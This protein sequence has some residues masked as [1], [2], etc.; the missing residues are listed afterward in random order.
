MTAGLLAP[1]VPRLLRRLE[2]PKPG[3]WQAAG[4]LVFADISG[5]TRM[6]EKLAHQGK[7]GAEEM[8]TTIS[9]VFTALLQATTDGGDVLKFGGDALLLLYQ[10]PDHAHRACHAALT[11]QRELRRVGGIDTSRGRV[12]LRM[13][14]G[15]HSGRFHFLLCGGDHL[16]LHVLGP[17]ATTTTVLES[18]AGPGQVVASAATAGQLDGARIQPLSDG[19]M[20]IRAVPP[21]PPLPL[22][23]IGGGPAVTRFVPPPLRDHLASAETDS[24]HR[25]ATVAFV[26]F[27]QVDSLLRDGHG[28]GAFDRV[29]TLTTDVMAALEEYGVLLTATDIGGDGGKFMLTAGAPRTTGDEEARMLRVAR[30]IID[31][32]CGLPIRVGVNAGNVFVGAVGAPHR[33]T[34]STMGDATNLAARVMGRAEPGTVL[35]TQTVNAAAAGRFRVTPRPEFRVKGKSQPVL[36]GVVGPAVAPSAGT[37][38]D[39]PLVGRDTE[40]TE[41]LDALDEARFGRGRVV[42]LIGGEGVGKSRLVAELHDRADGLNWLA[43][44]CEPY[45]QA[46]PFV[47]ARRLIRL[48]LDLSPD[49][50]PEAAADALG[51]AMA[52][53]APQLLPWLPLIADVV[54]TSAEPTDATAELAPEFRSE[55]TV[56]AAAALLAA[57][58]GGGVTVVVLE[59]ATAM[60][61]ASAEVITELLRMVPELPWLAVVTRQDRPEGL[62]A[63]RGYAARQLDLAPLPRTAISRLAARLAEHYPVPTHVVEELVDRAA[64][65]PMVLEALIAAQSTA[66]A[67][68]QVPHT[69]EGI[70]AARIDALDDQTRRI[71]RYL[72]V[73]GDRA[74]APLVTVM[75]GAMVLGEERGLQQADWDGDPIDDAW[76]DRLEG[77]VVR[78][79]DAVVFRT[80]LIRQVAYEGLSFRRRRELHGLAA[81]ALTGLGGDQA[82][83]ALHLARAGRWAAAWDTAISAGDAAVRRG[84]HAAAGELYDLALSAAPHLPDLPDRES[85]KVALDAGAAWTR[86]GVNERALQAFSQAAACA[87]DQASCIEVL[88]ARAAVHEQAGRYTQALQSYGRA[89]SAVEELPPGIQQRRLTARTHTGYASA[90]LGQGR[91]SDAVEVGL[92]AVA[93]LDDGDDPSLLAHA[94][95]LLDRGYAMLGDADTAARYRDLALPLFAAQGDLVAQGTVL[96]DLGADANRQ[97]Q[98][99]V[100]LWLHERSREARARAGD[101]VGSAA[102]VNAIGEVLLQLGRHEE[103]AERFSDALRAWRGA[104]SLPGVALALHNLGTVALQTGA[105][106]S[107]AKRLEE[108]RQLA[109]EVGAEGLLCRTRLGLAEAL[110]ELGRVVEAWDAATTVLASGETLETDQQ[111]RAHAVRARALALTGGN[112]RAA[113]EQAA[114]DRLRELASR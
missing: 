4:T 66:G 64:G 17:D 19:S 97:G 47:T 48:A 94:Y 85:F 80:A 33:R 91:A 79:D 81:T 95:H 34:Y 102:A 3:A 52:D 92:A 53:H 20:R 57:V 70:F 88:L 51:A 16:E 112:D 28:D 36:T 18:A 72:S 9:S 93:A 10:G 113:Q 40:L 107:A 67:D 111:A 89:R 7:R 12:R 110:T 14:I 43:V 96:F 30:R 2:D 54:G 59:D 63:D 105:A 69:I 13:S 77:F 22:P 101:V 60:D 75:L 82:T 24:E 5:F 44:A 78:E 84:A 23:D 49:A 25:R 76:W 98:H 1:Y 62:H 87:P 42:E 26:H 74:E 103:A 35:A 104:R 55:R 114:A 21:L 65:N 100:A 71:L 32:D 45:E 56:Q 31:T 73:L 109:E 39:A 90:R 37:V 108:A 38:S 83:I 8:V 41:L 15:V 68:A 61:D 29:Q 6:T 99:E 46:T 86:A 50:T 106:V 58:T 27:G 11:M